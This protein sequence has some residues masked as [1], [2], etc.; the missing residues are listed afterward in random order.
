M[1]TGAVLFP[2]MPFGVG[3]DLVMGPFM[4]TILLIS[5]MEQR[6]EPIN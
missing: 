1:C 5:S 2:L 3:A 4:Y 6:M